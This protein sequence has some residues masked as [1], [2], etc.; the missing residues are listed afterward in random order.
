M[1]RCFHL[2]QKAHWESPG[3]RAEQ[4]QLEASVLASLERAVKK[5]MP[6]GASVDT[7]DIAIA[8]EVRSRYERQRETPGR[9]Q[10]LVPS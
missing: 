4:F 1:K 5:A 8:S 10:Y 9:D 3:D 6:S 7:I 2:P